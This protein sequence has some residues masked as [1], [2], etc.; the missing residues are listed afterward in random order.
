MDIYFKP[1]RYRNG[2]EMTE[3]KNSQKSLKHCDY[4]LYEIDEVM[5]DELVEKIK[6]LDRGVSKIEPFYV[7]TKV[8][9]S[10]MRKAYEYYSLG[11]YDSALLVFDT[12][13]AFNPENTTCIKL[14]AMTLARNGIM[15]EAQQLFQLAIRLARHHV[16]KRNTY[17]AFGNFLSL[18]GDYESALSYLNYSIVY[19]FHNFDHMR[20]DQD[21]IGF[22]GSELYQKINFPE[23]NP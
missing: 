17:Y 19:G 4:Y 10:A 16:Q 20:A 21:L 12:I 15:D 7:R 8:V 9:N 14:K 13:L 1:N 2:G 18:N 3:I 23:G 22:R 6:K 5:S 11:K